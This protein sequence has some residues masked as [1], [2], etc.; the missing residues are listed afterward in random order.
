MYAVP[1]EDPSV[2]RG[3]QLYVQYA[4]ATCHRIH[5]EGGAIGPELSYVGD[6]RTDRS[7]H[8]KHFRNPQSVNPGSIMPK[9]PLSEKELYDLS[10]YMLSLKR[11]G[12]TGKITSTLLQAIDSFFKKG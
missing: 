8:I 7:W 4:C 6:R 12:D 9:F 5:G 11:N 1:R 2:A 3:K 10:S